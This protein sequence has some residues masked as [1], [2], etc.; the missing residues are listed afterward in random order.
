MKLIH[1]SKL[2]N[3]ENHLSEYIWF[4]LPSLLNVQKMILCGA[5]SKHSNRCTGFPVVFLGSCD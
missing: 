5:M 3:F 4:E 1:S 2:F